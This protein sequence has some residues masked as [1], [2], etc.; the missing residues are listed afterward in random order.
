MASIQERH[1][2]ISHL[3]AQEYIVLNLQFI[4]SQIMAS[5]IDKLASEG[6]P[7]LPVHDSVRCKVSDAERV[8]QVMSECY[9]QKTGFKARISE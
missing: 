3:L 1:S 8:K 9:L 2:A 5:V 4:D 6:I 7:V